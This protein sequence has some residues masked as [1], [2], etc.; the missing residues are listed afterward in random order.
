[1]FHS[2]TTDDLRN[3]MVKPIETTQHT[4]FFNFIDSDVTPKQAMIN[5]IVFVPPNARNVTVLQ[6]LLLDWKCVFRRA[7]AVVF[8]S[9]TG[10]LVFSA[11]ENFT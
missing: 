4:L 6:A 5:E 7:S 3:L 11:P 1:M 2:L 10:Q 9:G 8:L